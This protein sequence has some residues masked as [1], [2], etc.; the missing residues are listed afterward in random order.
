[1]SDHGEFVKAKEGLE[2][3]IKEASETVQEC[4]GD[5]DLTWIDDKLN[6]LNQLSGRMIEGKVLQLP[7]HEAHE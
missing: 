2:K 6:T 4:V 3:W 5:G 7:T 1:M